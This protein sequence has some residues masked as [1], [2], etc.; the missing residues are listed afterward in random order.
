[1]HTQSC[2]QELML[3]S[4]QINSLLKGMQ[5]ALNYVIIIDKTVLGNRELCVLLMLHYSP[6]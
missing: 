6:L 1:M 3:N 4:E 2:E 5:K